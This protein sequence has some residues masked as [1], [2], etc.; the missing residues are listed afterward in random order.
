MN[1]HFELRDH[2][3]LRVIGDAFIEKESLCQV[4]FVVS[5]EDVLLLEESE[6]HHAFV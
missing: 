1:P 2:V 6:Q 5:F 3:F 4:L